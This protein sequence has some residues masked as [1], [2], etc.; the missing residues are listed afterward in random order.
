MANPAFRD[1][2][3]YAGRHGNRRACS[4]GGRREGTLPAAAVPMAA[5]G[6]KPTAAA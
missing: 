2:Q 3:I 4:P 6:D 1:V 5:R